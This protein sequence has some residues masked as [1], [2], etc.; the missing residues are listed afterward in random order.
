MENHSSDKPGL[1]HRIWR[2]SK[3]WYLLWLPVGGV[4]AMIVGALAVTG[5][6][7]GL[8]LSNSNEFCY[9]CHIGMDTVVEEYQA[10]THYNNRSG[11]SPDCADC[12]VPKEF[13]P[14]MRVKAIALINLYE[15]L[16]GK[17]TLDNFEQFRLPLAEIV[18]EDM[19][20]SG[21][22]EC[23]NCH[24]PEQWDRLSQPARARTNH[25]PE[26]WAR[27][28]E[29]CIDCHFGIAHKRPTIE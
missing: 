8:K 23:R 17:Y 11:V 29:S 3:R 22:R 13:L 25:D 19:R 12:H 15:T 4:L 1:W 10:S 5:F 21:S 16:I 28:G 14:K 27:N 24:D 18:W 2:P 20:A 7:A 26:L 6:T 9:N